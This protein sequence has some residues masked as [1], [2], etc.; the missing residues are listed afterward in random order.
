[1]KKN[2]F[3]QRINDNFARFADW[4]LDHKLF[5]VIVCLAVCIGAGTLI[6]RMS[7]NFDPSALSPDDNVFVENY[8]KF[9]E[10]FGSAEVL[11]ILYSNKQGIFDID[12]LR[13]TQM[14]VEELKKVTYIKN[15]QSI[16]NL[17]IME[18]SADGEIRV[19]KVKD[20]FPA[21]QNESE[22]LKARFLDKPLFVNTYIS[23][24]AKYAA[25]LC[26][27][28]D[29]PYQREIRGNVKEILS[30][31]VYKDFKFYPVG[32]SLNLA[33]LYDLTEEN[34]ILFGSFSSILII[35]LLLLLF[36]QAK[37]LLTPF[38]VV[39]VAILFSLG[40]MVIFDLPITVL[41]SIVPSVLLGIGIA[42]AVHIISE[43]Q[44]HLLAGN[45]NR[46]SIIKTVKLVGFPCLFTTITTAIGFG[47]LG[48][49]SISATR[50]FGL[51]LSVGVV[52]ALAAT[53]TI[54][55]L[56]LSISGEKS[57]A[58]FKR[59]TMK[60]GHG[61]MNRILLGIAHFNL[62]HYKAVILI[63]AI[64]AIVLVYGTTKIKV[65]TS[66]LMQLG[67]KIQ[68]FRDFKFVDKTMGGTA[69]FEVLLDS[70]EADGV[71]TLQFAQ[72]LEKIQN[73]ASKE[74]YLVK[75]T[76]SVA[77]MM[78][79]A[80][81]ALNNNNK[82]FYRLPSS[83]GDEMQNINEFLYELHGGDDLMRFVTADF[84]KARVTIFVES[85]DS[86]IYDRFFCKLDSYIKSIKPAGYDYTITGSSFSAV[87][88]MHT[89]TG[90]MV[91]SLS[92]ALVLISIMMIFVFRSIKTGLLSM[93]P[94]MFPVLFALGFMG[95]NDI[96]LSHITS[97]IGC[98][99]IGLAV[100]DT[101]HFISRYRLEFDRLG[102]YKKALAA[103]MVG[104][105]RALSITTIILVIGFGVFIFSRMTTYYYAGMLTSLCFI[106][107]LS[108]DFFLAP[109]LILI[110]KPFG[111]EFTPLQNKDEE[112]SFHVS[113]ERAFV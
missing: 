5:V 106:V 8:E 16:T 92:L 81:R 110:F 76:I 46:T 62:K 25:I 85:S 101:I 97:I 12:T 102:D 61:F 10:E 26:E 84:S 83:E 72:T 1:M 6:P 96:W 30:K 22:K 51:I 9:N 29:M 107:A 31:P 99:V 66:V 47:S 53:F 69:S 45:D 98:V 87:T 91:K 37:G 55:L 95:L 89:I 39:T 28:E 70:K 60:K 38:V 48:T 42:D 88:A 15:A 111:K 73:F 33:T 35:A 104:V 17:E 82:A 58:R 27:M 52:A 86:A 78:K 11:Y 112:S 77:D 79:D 103:S 40:F 43:Y 21:N 36:R 105:G 75:K 74:D 71:K 63:Y 94:N 50:H 49:S 44:I 64:G 2:N 32:D 14:L 41:F 108:A 18:G 67:D 24:D 93:I 100:D 4:V 34:T 3:I 57:E 56:L 68:L 19:Y 54:L 80:N 113:E 90:T 13:K 23:K 59:P 20:E 7:A 109:A 65:N